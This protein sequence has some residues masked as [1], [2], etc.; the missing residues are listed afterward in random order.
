MSFASGALAGIIS[1]NRT[2][3]LRRGVMTKRFPTCGRVLHKSCGKR[4]M[5]HFEGFQGSN[6]KAC[7]RNTFGWRRQIGKAT[8][9]PKVGS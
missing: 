2:N 4:V 1:R 5:G 3:K 9:Q 8:D 6:P 7:E